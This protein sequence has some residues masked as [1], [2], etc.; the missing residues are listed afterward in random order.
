VKKALTRWGVIAV[1]ALLG[2]LQLVPYGRAHSNPPVQAEP[3]WDSP[4]TRALAARACFDCHSNETKWPW[5]SHVAPVSWL[6]QKHVDDGRRELNLSEWN[7]PQEG[8]EAVETMQ[9]GEMPLPSYL[10]AHPEAR[11]SPA[12]FQALVQG[13]AATLAGEEEQTAALDGNGEHDTDEDEHD[14]EKGHE[15]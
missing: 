3:V 12:E 4:Q 9:E 15:D 1:V 6:V 7:R 10:L 2:I 13:L 5:Y 8:G 11:L 14:E